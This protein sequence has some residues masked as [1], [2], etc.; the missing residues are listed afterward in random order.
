MDTSEDEERD[1]LQLIAEA[2]TPVTGQELRPLTSEEDSD[3]DDYTNHADG[4]TAK[5]WLLEPAIKKNRWIMGFIIFL[6]IT[7]IV[8]D[9]VLR[10]LAFLIVA[11][12]IILP[13]GYAI[14][15]VYLAAKKI[16]RVRFSSVWFFPY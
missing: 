4:T 3:D 8:T 5:C 11:L 7:G 12:L 13:S 9:N 10:G 16:G 14:L 1:T 6:F 2:D 15:H